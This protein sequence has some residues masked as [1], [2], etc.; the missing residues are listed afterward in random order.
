MADRRNLSIP[1]NLAF[2]AGLLAASHLATAMVPTYPKMTRA[3]M[4]AANSNASPLS[5]IEPIDDLSDG[6]Q[7][8]TLT[9]VVMP[10]LPDVAVPE[11]PVADAAVQQ[12]PVKLLPVLA[13]ESKSDPSPP[14][15][16]IPRPAGLTPP[17]PTPMRPDAS[18]PTQSNPPLIVPLEIAKPAALDPAS[19]L[20]PGSRSVAMAPKLLPLSQT[21]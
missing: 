3:E 20:S 7:V 14:T 19:P 10:V 15:P 13:A 2:L 16:M 4:M 5:T 17:G 1:I 11:A 18:G 21:D 6:G 12:A 9:A 8:M